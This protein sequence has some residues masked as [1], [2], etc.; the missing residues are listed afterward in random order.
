LDTKADIIITT[1][2]ILRIDVD[3]VKK[4]KWSML[5]VDEAQNI[6][7]P[8]TSQTQAVKAIKS[9]IKI[10]MT[11]T[12]VENKLTELWSIF[13]FI[14]RGYLGSMRDFQK[15]YAIPIEKFKQTNRAEKL[16]LAISPFVLRR[17]KT[18][19]T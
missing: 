13:D 4:Q 6:K 10:A 19:K 15:G 18:D 16:R 9:D 12:P 3:K 8:D 1:Y 2:A 5:I 7:N 17:L 11:G 14:N